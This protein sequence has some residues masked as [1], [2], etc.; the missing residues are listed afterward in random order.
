MRR[1][2]DELREGV[3]ARFEQLH[4]EALEIERD[5]AEEIE[6]IRRGETPKPRTEVIM[7][8]GLDE[9][10]EDDENALYVHEDEYEQGGIL[11]PEGSETPEQRA[12]REK[13][14]RKVL[15]IEGESNRGSTGEADENPPADG[16]KGS[17]GGSDPGL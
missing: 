2:I 8:K 7:Y 10:P 16:E 14:D 17:P 13:E 9:E 15:D 11:V 4:Q 5:A 12:A 1:E 6:A 3:N